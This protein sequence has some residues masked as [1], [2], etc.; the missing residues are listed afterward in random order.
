MICMYVIFGPFYPMW[1]KPQLDRQAVQKIKNCI[2]RAAQL[3]CICFARRSSLEIRWKSPKMMVQFLWVPWHLE[4][5]PRLQLSLLNTIL[6]GQHIRMFC[7]FS[8]TKCVLKMFV[9]C[10]NPISRWLE[11]RNLLVKHAPAHFI[12][13]PQHPSQS[14][15]VNPQEKSACVTCVAPFAASYNPFWDS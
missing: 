13:W 12:P 2:L 9:V 14:P 15:A 5:L 10:I 11:M 7:R 6:A 1:L 4:R 8:A 3:G